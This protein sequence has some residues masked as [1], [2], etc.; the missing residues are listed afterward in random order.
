MRFGLGALV[1][2]TMMP[3]MHVAMFVLHGLM[4]MFVVVPLRKMQ[5]QTEGHQQPRRDE[6]QGDRLVQQRQGHDR[7][8]EGSQREIRP[9]SRASEVTQRKDE[10][11]QAH[12]DAKKSNDGRGAPHLDGRQPCAT[13]QSQRQVHAPGGEPLDKRDLDGVGGRQ[14]PG[15]VV[16]DTPCDAGCRD[17]NAA[18]IAPDTLSLPGQN[19]GSGENRQSTGQQPPIDVLAERDPGD[20]HRS[21]SLEVEQQRS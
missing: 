9:R 12:A 8:D 18:A 10:Q 6:L 7:A 21:Q 14:L 2:M 1:T 5:P 17:Q 19:D 11:H 4:R 20:T 15:K 16:V 13:R 3:V